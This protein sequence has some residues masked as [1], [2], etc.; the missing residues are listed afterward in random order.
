MLVSV[1]GLMV[2]TSPC[3]PNI[4]IRDTNVGYTLLNRL[5]ALLQNAVCVLLTHLG[6]YLVTQPRCNREKN[7]SLQ[8]GA[9]GRS[10]Q[11]SL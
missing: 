8:A 4:S 7:D 9:V 6:K 3:Q 10:L 5:I 2:S 1:P 11:L